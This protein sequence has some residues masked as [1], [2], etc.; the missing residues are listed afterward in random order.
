MVSTVIPTYWMKILRFNRS[1]DLSRALELFF[2][3]SYLFIHERY[4][5]RER[6]REKESQETET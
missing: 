1:K 3:R 4:T 2:L 6:E 5:E